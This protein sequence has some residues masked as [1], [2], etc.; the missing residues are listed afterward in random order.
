MQLCQM[1][2][3]SNKAVGEIYFRSNKS[4]DPLDIETRSPTAKTLR[5]QFCSYLSAVHKCNS[6]YRK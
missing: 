1:I 4:T 6:K 5:C 2:I 3:L